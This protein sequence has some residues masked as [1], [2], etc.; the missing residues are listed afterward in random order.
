MAARKAS[1]TNTGLTLH[2]HYTTSTLVCESH[3][4]CL[5]AKERAALRV[6]CM[7]HK[8]STLYIDRGT[9]NQ[10]RTNR[11]QSSAA[12]TTSHVLCMQVHPL[13]CTADRR[14]C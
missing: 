3:S 7:Y 11:A 2:L 6:P 14:Y 12:L 5:Q 9:G 4:V 13:H 10:D 1:C 8:G